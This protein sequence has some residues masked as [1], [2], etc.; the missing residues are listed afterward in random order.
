MD[1]G[2]RLDKNTICSDNASVTCNG[3]RYEGGVWEYPGFEMSAPLRPHN[4]PEV[5]PLSRHCPHQRRHQASLNLNPEPGLGIIMSPNGAVVRSHPGPS[6]QMSISFVMGL[7]AVLSSWH[8][9]LTRLKNYIGYYIRMLNLNPLSS[10]LL[11]SC[12]NYNL[13]FCVKNHCL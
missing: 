5:P 7:M 8:I 12:K 11:L 2:P 3:A 9:S 4:E 1:L 10:I 6:H 13:G